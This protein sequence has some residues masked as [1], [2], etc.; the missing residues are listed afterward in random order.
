MATKA[1]YA[2]IC[3]RMQHHNTVTVQLVEYLKSFSQIVKVYYPAIDNHQLKGYGSL[4]FFQLRDDLIEKYPLFIKTLKLFD[5]GT[6]MACV[7]SMVAQPYTGSHASMTDNEKQQMGLNKGLIRLSF[8]LEDV[9][10][11]KQDLKNAFDIIATNNY[12][13]DHK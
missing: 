7:T 11:L 1:Q 6:G 5:T 12:S 9:K 13:K 10:D 2:D 3:V 8:G 4:I